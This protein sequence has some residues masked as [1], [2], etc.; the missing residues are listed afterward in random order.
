MSVTQD[1]Q[2]A[3]ATHPAT[4][5][6][7][8]HARARALAAEAAFGEALPAEPNW[9]GFTEADWNLWSAMECDDTLART[10]IPIS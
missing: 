10:F 3:V 6:T 8:S 5:R 9:D 4:A 7:D 2:R 1:I